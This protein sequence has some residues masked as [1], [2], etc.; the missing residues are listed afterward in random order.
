M[1]QES[2]LISP[3]SNVQTV[4]LARCFINI[5]RGAEMTTTQQPD[6]GGCSIDAAKRIPCPFRGRGLTVAA[7][8]VTCP[9][10]RW[11]GSQQ[12]RW[13]I[14][15]SGATRVRPGAG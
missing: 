12:Q 15:A 10:M 1:Y 8:P 11:N 13:L 2:H 9:L 7:G 3:I 6:R 5:D 14:S 4:R